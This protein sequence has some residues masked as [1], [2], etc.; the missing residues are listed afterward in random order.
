[1]RS[2]GEADPRGRPGARL[3]RMIRRQFRLDRDARR[4]GVRLEDF[5]DRARRRR[6]DGG[7]GRRLRGMEFA[8]RGREMLLHSGGIGQFGL[9]LRHEGL[10]RKGFGRPA[11]SGISAR[12]ST[13]GSVHSGAGVGAGGAIMGCGAMVCGAAGGAARTARRSPSIIARRS[14]T[15]P[16]V[17]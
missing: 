16:S 4:R 9:G 10:R 6:S 2:E 3:E 1:M 15:W 5:A 11:T 12:A 17:L 14:T 13:R 8:R 7:H